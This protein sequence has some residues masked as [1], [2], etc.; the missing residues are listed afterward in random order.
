MVSTKP[1]KTT[2]EQ[3]SVV[4]WRFFKA[5][6]ER[7]AEPIFTRI[8][9]MSPDL[10]EMIVDDLYGANLARTEVLTWKETVLIEFVGWYALSLRLLC[11]CC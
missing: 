4:G 3:D 6:Y 10:A 1:N 5:I 9:A 7:H 8:N 11:L 2:T